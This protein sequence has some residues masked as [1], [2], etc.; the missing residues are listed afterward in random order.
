MTDSN[1][2]L[3]SGLIASPCSEGFGSPEVRKARAR[4]AAKPVSAGG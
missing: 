2:D 3:L 1:S 4:L